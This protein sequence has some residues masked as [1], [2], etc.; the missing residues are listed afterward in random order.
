MVDGEYNILGYYDMQT[1]NLTWYNREKWIDGNKPPPDRT[2]IVRRLK[3]V[4]NSLFI[5]LDAISAIG[6]VWSIGLVCFNYKFRKFRFE[7][8][9][10]CS[11]LLI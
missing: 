4:S 9:P 8:F 6:I 7:H 10:L 1:E 2:I 5:T 11:R 3:T